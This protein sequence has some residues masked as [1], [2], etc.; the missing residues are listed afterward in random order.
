MVL[1]LMDEHKPRQHH[2]NSATSENV[3]VEILKLPQI[4]QGTCT[5]LDKILCDVPL[6]VSPYKGGVINRALYHI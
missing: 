5:D 1:K 4:M 2:A 6:Y 3:Q